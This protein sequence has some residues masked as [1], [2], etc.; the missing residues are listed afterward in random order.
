MN[1]IG[2]QLCDLINSGLIRWWLTGSMDVVAESGRNSV[3]K[4]QVQPDC[5]E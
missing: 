2:T 1:V 3:S 4:H 5:G